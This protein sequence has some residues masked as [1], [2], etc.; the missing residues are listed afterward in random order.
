MK[1]LGYTRIDSS[2]PCLNQ[3]WDERDRRQ[4]EAKAAEHQR[5]LNAAVDAGM[6]S[7]NARQRE[8]WEQDT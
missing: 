5:A 4:R 1:P 3:F 8:M 7:L 2:L 6:N